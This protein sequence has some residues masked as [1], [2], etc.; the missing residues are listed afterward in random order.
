[1]FIKNASGNFAVGRVS[2]D[3]ETRE[4]ANGKSKA[5][6][7]IMYADDKN[8]VDDN[9]RPRGLFLTIDAWGAVARDAMLLEKGD[10]VAVV[11]RLN[12]H[13]YNGKQYTELVADA[14][15]PDMGAIMRIVAHGS[16]GDNPGNNAA[17][18]SN[19][20]PADPFAELSDDEG[21]LPF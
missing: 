9:C 20:V 1:M 6:F 2:R 10:F 7:S 12:Q 19:P 18:L 8:N 16:A 5:Q 11:G 21:E 4:F 17:G 13:E 14:I 15:F 3:P